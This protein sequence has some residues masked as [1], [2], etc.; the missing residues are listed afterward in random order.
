MSGCSPAQ[1]ELFAREM[2]LDLLSSTLFGEMMPYYRLGIG[3]SVDTVSKLPNYTDADKNPVSERFVSNLN[4]AMRSGLVDIV[5][6]ISHHDGHKKENKSK[7]F[8]CGLGSQIESLQNS[9]AKHLVKEQID[10]LQERQTRVNKLEHFNS[11]NCCSLRL[12]VYLTPAAFASINVNAASFLSERS[13]HGLMTPIDGNESHVNPTAEV[14]SKHNLSL[15]M[16][17]P[18]KTERFRSILSVLQPVHHTHVDGQQPVPPPKDDSRRSLLDVKLYES[19]HKF[20]SISVTDGLGDVELRKKGE[21]IMKEL[22][23][24]SAK[25]NY[26]TGPD[27]LHEAILRSDAFTV[28][29][30]YRRAEPQPPNVGLPLRLYQRESLAWMLDREQQRSLSDPFWI[31][32]TTVDRENL[33]RTI[34]YCPLTGTVSAAQPPP[35]VGGVLAEEMGL[36]KTIIVI[37]LIDLTLKQA[38]QNR[39][40]RGAHERKD[41][42]PTSATL[43]V[44]PVSLLKQWEQEF[45]TKLRKP[46]RVLTWYGNRTKDPEVIASYDVV[47]TTYGILSSYRYEELTKLHWYRVVIDE[48]TYLRGGGSNCAGVLSKELVSSRRWA[49]SGTPFGNH[50]ASF[51]GTMRFLGVVPFSTT[52]DFELISAPFVSHHRYSRRITGE[53]DGPKR[54]PQLAYVLKNLVMRHVKDQMFRGNVLVK[55]PPASGTLVR[56]K[57]SKIEARTYNNIERDV[58]RATSRK[59]DKAK[60]G[61]GDVLPLMQGLLPLRMMADG[62]MPD[63]DDKAKY[64]DPN[65]ISTGFRAQ[66]ASKQLPGGLQNKAKIRQ[67]INDVSKYRSEN[68]SNKFVIFS[69]FRDVQVAIQEELEAAGHVTFTLDGAMTAVKR[70]KV[71]RQFS[72]DMDAAAMIFSMRLGACGLTLTMAN[73]V[74]LFDVGLDNAL[75]LQ[76][77]NRTHRIGQTRAVRTLTYVTE[78]TVDERI[79]D[80][81]RK[82][83]LPRYFGDTESTENNGNGEEKL[84]K[85]EELRCL[86][87]WSP[88]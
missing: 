52:H 26:D 68:L 49:V 71:I 78:G 51:R 15:V 8:S 80:V 21:D 38:C 62:I 44:C 33:K 81:R 72:E 10:W 55:L 20:A 82:R 84:S 16:T 86:Y 69:E 11:S 6:N 73:F 65:R 39:F 25:Y 12:D 61:R 24:I 4:K 22:N 88:C 30:G 67:L 70:G 34:Y 9:V 5:W 45:K 59:L 13:I 77:V 19:E 1:A 41:L 18:K 31:P 85:M 66:A 36:G 53:Q 35:V 17:I 60:L 27:V 79:M 46:L 83:G 28:S 64:R 75:E 2:G 3:G 7:A 87:N 32:F 29:T 54:L 40:R 42:L 56:V 50:F 43:I 74:V 48:S 57:S 14:L 37:S 63:A 76:A 58:Q 23:N 47:L